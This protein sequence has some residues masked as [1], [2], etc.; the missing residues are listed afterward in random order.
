M[1]EDRTTTL[2]IDTLATAWLQFTELADDMPAGKVRDSLRLAA[3]ITDSL[4]NLRSAVSTVIIE[5]ELGHLAIV[6]AAREL[7]HALEESAKVEVSPILTPPGD[8]LVT[9]S[10]EGENE[11]M[12]IVPDGDK[13]LKVALIMLAQQDALR[14]GDK[15]T[16]EWYRRPTLVDQGL[17]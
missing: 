9:F 2:R 14:A 5:L 1:A 11:L 10:R 6:D 4:S 17:A 3:S 8:L 7:R 13:A 16:V 15:I 12:H